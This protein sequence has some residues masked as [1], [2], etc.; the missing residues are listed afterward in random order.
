[1]PHAQFVDHVYPLWLAPR[2]DLQDQDTAQQVVAELVSA[3]DP[4]WLAAAEQASGEE[5]LVAPTTAATTAQLQQRYAWVTPQGKQVKLD[6]A[7]VATF[8]QL[9]LAP[10]LAQR[11]AKHATF[12]EAVNAGLP[13]QLQPAADG[14]QLGKLL[15]KLWKL[16]WDN[17]KKECFWRMTVNGKVSLARMHA[18]GGSCA[19][20]AVAPGILHHFWQCPVAQEVVTVLSSCL[21]GLSRPLHQVHVWM[22]RPPKAAVH[23][24]VWLVVSQAALLGMDQGRG[25]LYKWQKQ[26]DTPGEQPLPAHLHTPQQRQQAA[27]RVAVAAF[28]DRL[29]DFVGLRLCPGAWF[30]HIATD[31][32]FMCKVWG[33]E[34]DWVLRV[35]K[36]RG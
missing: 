2:V 19:C 8:T 32:P 4:A 25:L 33:E 34:G 7:T 15:A 3:V 14:V 31:H 27:G 24:G 16:P 10:L 6:T 35:N 28:W 12:L 20:G 29:H 30:D 17:A 13:Q 5:L 21:L 36:E 11:A 26:L 23:K 1:M 22:A 18:V 9:Q